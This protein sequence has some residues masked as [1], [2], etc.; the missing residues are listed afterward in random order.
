MPSPDSWLEQ[1][2]KYT[3]VCLMDKYGINSIKINEYDKNSIFF[4][5]G[6]IYFDIDVMSEFEIQVK[7]VSA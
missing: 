4:S 3:L 7:M 6:Y 1:Y 5:F 2:S